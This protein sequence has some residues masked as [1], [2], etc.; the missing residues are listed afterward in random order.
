LNDDLPEAQ[1]HQP[2]AQTERWACWDGGSRRGLSGRCGDLRR[3][4]QPGGAHRRPTKTT[5]PSLFASFFSD[6]AWNVGRELAS[7]LQGG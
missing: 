7:L 1:G 6:A 2:G 4:N 3:T 5:S